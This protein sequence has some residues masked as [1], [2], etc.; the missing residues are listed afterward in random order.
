MAF[1]E[2]IFPIGPFGIS[3]WGQPVPPR[4]IL[5]QQIGRRAKLARLARVRDA[6]LPL[7]RCVMAGGSHAPPTSSSLTD[8]AFLQ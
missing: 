5:G 2:W 8:M 6:K 4:V 3:A 1:V 7:V